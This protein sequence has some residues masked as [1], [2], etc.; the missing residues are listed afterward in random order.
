MRLLQIRDDGNLTFTEN[1]N[2]DQIP[3]YAILSHTWGKPTDEV[4]YQDMLDGSATAKVGFRKIK[5]CAEQAERDG[6]RYIWVDTCCIDKPN[7]SELQESINSMFKWYQKAQVCYAY[8]QDISL[9]GREAGSN[10]ED[11]VESRLRNSRWFTRGWTL[12][13]LIAPKEVLFYSKEWTRVGDKCSLISVI[14][15]ITKTPAAGL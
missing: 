14:C 5:F 6:L 4:T 8:L 3:R 13:E 12:Q 2:D 9:K 7:S 15:D 11:E 10:S 1:F